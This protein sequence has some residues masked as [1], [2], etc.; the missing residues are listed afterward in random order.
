MRVGSEAHVFADRAAAGRALAQ[1]LRPDKFAEPLLVLGLPRGGVA[2][3]YEVAA[4]LDAPLDVLIVRKIALPYDP[5]LAVGAAA[6]GGVVV[7]DESVAPEGDARFES[8]RREALEEIARRERL[9]R[10]GR[11]PLDLHGRTVILVD[12]GL[13]T[14]ATMLAAV[15]AAR[16]AGAATIVAA[17]PV[18]SR[19]AAARVR[20]EV[21]SLVVLETPAHLSAVGQWFE[22]FEQLD[23]NDVRRLLDSAP[24]PRAKG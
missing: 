23:D 22:R 19:Q 14:G 13:A 1:A 10:P 9:Y 3:A 17:A 11:A 20:R 24:H 18:A 12:D 21:D 2:V 4:A 7:W 16:R 5:E 8:L 15:Q 6:S